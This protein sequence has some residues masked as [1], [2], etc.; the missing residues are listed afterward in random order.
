MSQGLHNLGNTCSVNTLV[1]CI[2]HCSYLREMLLPAAQLGDENGRDGA[3]KGITAEIARLLKRLWIDRKAVAPTGLLKAIFSS[4]GGIMTPGEQ[5]DMSELWMLLSDKINDET[6]KPAEYPNIQGHGSGADLEAFRRAWNSHNSKCMSA[7]L[8]A[9]QG[10]TATRIRCGSCSREAVMYE[11]FCSL[12]LDVCQGHTG[13][14]QMFDMMFRKEEV[15]RRECDYCKGH[16]PAVKSTT[17]CMYPKVLVVY[18][19]RFGSTVDGRMKKL[20]NPINIPTNM[21]FAKLDGIYR[22]CAIG[23]H[24]GCL[25]GGHYFATARCEDGSWNVCDDASISGINDIGIVLSANR[26]AYMLVYEL[27]KN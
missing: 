21:R 20:S 8:Q 9:V 3:R 18:F 11:P 14:D 4:F 19:K 24:V 7:W 15:A 5:L 17:I 23:N 25:D 27:K 12:G 10:W 6:G 22:L 16:H 26:E 2:C 1:Q 13:L